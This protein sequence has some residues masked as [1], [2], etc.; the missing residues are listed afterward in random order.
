MSR[1]HLPLLSLYLPLN[2]ALAWKRKLQVSSL[3]QQLAGGSQLQ[4]TGP[5]GHVA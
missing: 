1:E 5:Q 4:T 2:A 3:K